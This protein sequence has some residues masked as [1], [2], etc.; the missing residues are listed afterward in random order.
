[1]ADFISNL[2]IKSFRGISDLELRELN[3]INILTGDNNSGKTSVLEVLE[4]LTQ[5]CSFRN[6]RSLLRKEVMRPAGFGMSYYEAF[7][8]LFNAENDLKS[9]EYGA[10]FGED[11]I[12]LK[13]TG[14]ETEEEMS[15]ESYVKN[16]QM[17]HYV[18]E[19]EEMMDDSLIAVPKLQ[20]KL[21]I[22]GEEIGG[23]EI[24]DGGSFNGLTG[25]VIKEYERK[26]IYISPVRHA[27]GS[28]YLT[29]ILNDPEL[30]EEMLEVLK[31]YDENIISINYVRNERGMGG[32]YKILS[33]SHK[34][35]L[36]LNVYGDGM[37]KAAL[38][39]SAVVKAKDGILLLDEFETAIHTSAM[40]KTFQWIL[41]TCRK[42][43]VQLFLTSHSREAI[44]KVL[45]CAPHLQDDITVYTLYKEGE[46]TSVRRL[47]GKKAI[48]AQDDMGLELR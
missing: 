13:M 44:N 18:K 23:G 30:Y 16:V 12:H 11:S 47:P 25:K 36:P 4:S 27:E 28:L 20:L 31:E 32:E 10:E 2:N 9:I 46:K 38:L 17:V 1:M 8:H 7:L 14:S 43:H 19:K 41:E 33:R 6:W 45:K 34:K 37:K 26:I 39:M 21:E 15:A 42:L 24:C 40:D 35:A 22:N 48:E 3:K 5:P 29:E